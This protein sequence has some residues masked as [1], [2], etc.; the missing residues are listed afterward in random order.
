MHSQVFSKSKP[1]LILA[2]FLRWRKADFV[3]VLMWMLKFS[4]KFRT[5]PRFPAWLVV[6]K[7]HWLKPSN[8]LLIVL[9]LAPKTTLLQFCLFL[10][11]ESSGT[12]SRGLLQCIYSM[13]VL[14]V[15]LPWRPE[16]PGQ[17]ALCCESSTQ[18]HWSGLDPGPHSITYRTWMQWWENSNILLQ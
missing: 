9:L 12:S 10:I 16:A 6:F 18:W 17:T 13:F 15:A 14:S 3:T 4:S 7:H 5:T 8:W 11:E 2:I 1:P